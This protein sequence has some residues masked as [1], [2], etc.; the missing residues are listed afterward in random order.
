MSNGKKKGAKGGGSVYQRKDRSGWFADVPIGINRKTGR[1]MRKTLHAETQ[2]EVM[3]MKKELESKLTLG[4]YKPTKG[5]TVGSWL[6]TWLVLKKPLVAKKTYEMYELFIRVHIKPELGH[7]KLEQLETRHIEALINKKLHP[8]DGSKSMSHRGTVAI[9][10]TLHAALKKAQGQGL[11][12]VNAADHVEMKR[13]RRKPI[14]QK[15]FTLGEMLVFLAETE[16]NP[17]H[18]IWKLGFLTGIRRSELLALR[19]EDVDFEKG[20]IRVSEQV[21]EG[22]TISQTL[23]SQYSHAVIPVLPIALSSLQQY[24]LRR[25]EEMLKYRQKIESSDLIFSKYDKSPI[26]PE[27]VTKSFRKERDRLGLRR[28]LTFHSTR[29]TY[30]TLGTQVGIETPKLMS[31]MRHSDISTTMIYVDKMDDASYKTELGKLQ[32]AIERG[33]E[34]QSKRQ[35]T[36]A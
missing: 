30:A 7:L 19:W 18:P 9:R 25:S 11:I 3:Q 8:E 6:D 20:T 24:R 5:Y 2:G 17:H 23:K 13:Q 10:Q 14:R 33:L 4:I 27:S 28:D 31:L 32:E 21:T 29:H 36:G 26:N 15:A 35:K 34:E 22:A 16:R 12:A 1:V